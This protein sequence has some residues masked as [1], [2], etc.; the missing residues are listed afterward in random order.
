M[1]KANKEQSPSIRLSVSP[2]T[3]FFPIL[4]E[5]TAVTSSPNKQLFRGIAQ[6]FL[7]Y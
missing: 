7:T 4:N 5:T 2:S 6:F 1:D 3:F